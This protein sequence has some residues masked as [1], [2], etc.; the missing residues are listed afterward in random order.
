MDQKRFPAKVEK[1]YST[2]TS[3]DFLIKRL[4]KYFDAQSIILATTKFK[5]DLKQS[6]ITINME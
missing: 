1:V 5:M 2:D 6:N 3:I 4:K